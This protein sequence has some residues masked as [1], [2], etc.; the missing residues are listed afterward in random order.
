M[1]WTKEIYESFRRLCKRLLA[2]PVTWLANKVSSAPNQRIVFEALST[3]Y[4]NAIDPK[5]NKAEF[6]LLTDNSMPVIILSD[7][8]KGNRNGADD[9]APTEST[10]LEALH[11]Y[12]EKGY[13]YIN[14]GD[15]EE[16]WKNNIFSIL[17]H[18]KATF[19]AERL[20]VDREAYCKVYGNHD[21]F[22]KHD[23]LA[24]QYLKQMYG[25]SV[26]V[27][28]GIVL[29]LP[30]KHEPHTDILCTHG[31]Q[32]DGQSDGN[33]L[34]AMIVTYIWGPL[35]AFLQVNTNTPA[36]MT[37]RKTL[38][39]QMMYAWS[40]DQTNLKLITGHTHQPVFE[41]LTHLER[42]YLRLEEARNKDDTTVIAAIE[43]EIPKRKL[44]Y[45]Y[46][47]QNYRSLKPTYFNTGCCCFSDGTISG[48]EIENGQIRLVLW[49]RID[50]TY[51]RIVAEVAS[52]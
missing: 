8:H 41:S 50:G 6:L 28:G 17:R 19:E 16:L 36:H 9:F 47:N 3:V 46:V 30:A 26:P 35:Q 38:H 32:G 13:Y 43:Q 45:D 14:L 27:Y 51:K 40:A 1:K 31:H 24:Q 18:N 48:I 22:W 2:R 10:Y 11:Y 21:L 34:S 33:W 52:I 12:N 29:R 15:S 5:S 39:N 7:Q 44:Q 4:Q 25:K 49:K 42:L 23:P 20:F 37:E